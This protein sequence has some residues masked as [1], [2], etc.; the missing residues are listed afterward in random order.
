MDHLTAIFQRRLK[1]STA[2]KAH[3]KQALSCTRLLSVNCMTYMVGRGESYCKEYPREYPMKCVVQMSSCRYLASSTTCIGVRMNIRVEDDPILRFASTSRDQLGDQAAALI[4]SNIAQPKSNCPYGMIE[5]EVYEYVLRL[6]V[7]QCGD[8]EQVF[9]ALKDVL[10]YSQAYTDYNELKKLYDSRR[11]AKRR[12]Q[13]VKNLISGLKTYRMKSLTRLVKSNQWLSRLINHCQS[14]SERLTPPPTYFESHFAEKMD[15]HAAGADP[16]HVYGLRVTSDYGEM[17][18]TYRDF[19]CRVCYMYNCEEHAIEHVM[20]ARRVDPVYPVLRNSARSSSMDAHFI[21]QTEYIDATHTEMVGSVLKKFASPDTPCSASC[22]KSSSSS[23]PEATALSQAEILLV[24]KIG[25]TM[26]DVPCLTAC[27]VQWVS[28]KT[29][30][31][32]Y[33]KTQMEARGRND[34]Y[35]DSG[36]SGGVGSKKRNWK[37][38]RGGSYRLGSN[39]ELLKRTRNKRLHDKGNDHQ[40]QPCN[41]DG[42]CDSIGCSCMTRDHMCEKACSC[43]RDCPNRY[44]YFCIHYVWCLL[45][46]EC[47][48]FCLD[49]KAADVNP[50][51]VGRSRAPVLPPCENVTLTCAPTV[52]LPTPPLL[53][54]PAV[55]KLT[56]GLTCCVV[57]FTLHGEP[58]R[59]LVFGILRHTVGE[60]LRWRISRRATS[61]MS[62]PEHSYRMMRQKGVG[63]STQ[64]EH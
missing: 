54:G 22:W 58:T 5:E 56:C 13:N 16:E 61:C 36:M 4:R 59:K 9:R 28:C 23:S 17:A 34:S 55:R 30:H 37:Q 15:E 18:E 64:I 8:S 12:L 50:V 24:K 25:C 31:D 33:E 39:R 6:V 53:F 2:E 49:L 21:D 19:F 51:A 38:G 62:T 27:F 41:H 20:P 14:L 35:D 11:V 26:G 40:Y 7:A 60:R 57:I 52:V 45:P 47:N 42:V 48:E 46:T 3:A 32:Y 63:L 10:G 44:V 29:I 1:V 43:S